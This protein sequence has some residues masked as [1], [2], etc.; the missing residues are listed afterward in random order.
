MG[1]E[2]NQE[3]GGGRREKGEAAVSPSLCSWERPGAGEAYE[4]EGAAIAGELCRG[5]TLADDRP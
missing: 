5:P 2:G 1:E 4:A 3:R